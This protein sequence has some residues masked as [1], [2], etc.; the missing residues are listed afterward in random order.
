LVVFITPHIVTQ[1]T[2]SAEEQKHLENTVFVSPRL[3]ET[4]YGNN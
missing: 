3:P 4:R 2:L 1:P